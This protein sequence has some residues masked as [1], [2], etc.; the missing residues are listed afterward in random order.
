MQ[1]HQSIEHGHLLTQR[2][3]AE[4]WRCSLRKL[5]RQRAAGEGP[6]FVR[7]GGSV[8]YLVEDILAFENSNRMTGD[9]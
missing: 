5:H 9:Q 2:D 4:R 3:V 6:A 1:Q 7:I 8:R